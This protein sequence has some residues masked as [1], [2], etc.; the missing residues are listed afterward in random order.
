MRFKLFFNMIQTTVFHILKNKLIQ[1]Y[2]KL[3]CLNNI[4]LFNRIVRL[5]TSFI[6]NVDF[7]F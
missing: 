4:Y 1:E 6:I 5:N 2:N 7:D 3:I